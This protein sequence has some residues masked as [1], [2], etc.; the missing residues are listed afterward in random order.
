[1]AATMK[2][3]KA[4]I[5]P[6]ITTITIAIA[7]GTS[8]VNEFPFSTDVP[9]ANTVVVEG[10]ITNEYKNH[11]IYV[12]R[13]SRYQDTSRNAL[14]GA[15]VAVSSG[16]S[17]FFYSETESG[18]YT[19]DNKFIGISNQVY[20]LHIEINDTIIISAETTMKPC[21][22]S[23]P[24]TFK[25][26]D[27]GKLSIKHV[28]EP[29]VPENPAKYIIRINW[30]ENKKQK[31]A[32]LY[33]YS[34]TTVNIAELFA[35]ETQETFFPA[36]AEI[37][38]TKYSLDDDYESYIRSLLAETMWSGGYFDEAHGNLHSNIKTESRNVTTA[39][40][41]SASTIITDTIIAR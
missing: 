16:D 1:M 21:T 27:N 22:P 32:T 36:G 30:Q 33:Y 5:R 17:T 39:G 20:Y 25:K 18:V 3:T 26:H 6:I 9:Q 7:C 28:A 41:F 29:Y 4:T 40:Y 12:S 14:R 35:P 23:D 10:E 11:K 24:I 37:I 8:C 38:E 13:L 2:F 15:K 34:L 31:N 19:S